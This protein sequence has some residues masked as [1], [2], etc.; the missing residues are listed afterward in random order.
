MNRKRILKDLRD[1]AVVLAAIAALLYTAAAFGQDGVTVEGF[2]EDEQRV[3]VSIGIA[4]PDTAKP[5]EEIVLRITGSPSLDLAL[6][7]VDQLDWLM[8]DNRMFVYWLAP[9]EP[10]APLDVRGELVF[11]VQGATM[12]PLVRVPCGNPG[13]Y[14]LLVDWN[15][16]QDQLCEHVVTVEGSKPN[17]QPGPEPEPNPNPTPPLSDLTVTIIEERDLYQGSEGAAINSHLEQIRQYLKTLSPE[18]SQWSLID[19]DQPAAKPWVAIL[20]SEQV[21]TPA[22]TV[23]A[24]RQEQVAPELIGV[25]DFSGSDAS[26]TIEELKKLGVTK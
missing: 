22:L 18:W 10:M 11:G 16:G 5:A 17:P 7:L 13:E 26:Q 15:S 1:F 4:G 12:Q 14:R 3:A 6:P 2:G 23:T 9:G 20:K 24:Q 19:Q 25:V 21:A 8:G